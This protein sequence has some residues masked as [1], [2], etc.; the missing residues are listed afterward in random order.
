[1]TRSRIA[2]I[3]SGVSGLGAAWAL[4]SCADVTVFESDQRLGGHSN[5]VDAVLDGVTTPVDTGFI[6]YNEPNYPNLTGL[7]K[8]LVV[9]TDPSDMSFAVSIDS[10]RLEY[11][12]TDLVGMFAQR[13]N[14]LRPSYWRMLLEI[15]RFYKEAQALLTAPPNLEQTLGDFLKVGRYGEAFLYDHLLPMGAAIWST[16]VEE[17][18]AFPA[19]SFARFF[20]NHGLLSLNDRPAW[21]TVRGGSRVYVAR[22]AEE[23]QARLRLGVGLRGVR[24]GEDGVT[25]ILPD[26]TEEQFDQVIFACPA[27]R[28]LALLADAADLERDALGAFTFQPNRAWLHTDPG[29]MPQRRRAWASW[30]YLGDG[31]ADRGRAVSLTY[32][33]NRLQNLDPARPVFVTLNPAREPRADLVQAVIDYRHPVFNK[34][35]WT[36]QSSIEAL[37]GQRRTWHCGAW[38][39]YGFHEDGLRSGLRAALALGGSVPW[40]HAMSPAG[41]Q[42]GKLAATGGP[43]GSR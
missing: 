12:G 3:G 14:L 27:D 10:G 4:R 21:R 33:M 18:L 19:L 8:A 13:R 26:G 40:D 38:L 22:I 1:M 41:S 28:S 43:V 15:T 5:T 32:W 6:V 2:I 24:R 34:A 29:L 11:S 25:A 23:S 35:A 39:G 42:A 30:N 17:M 7:F 37:Q 36:A 9:E 16:P 31:P 20:Q